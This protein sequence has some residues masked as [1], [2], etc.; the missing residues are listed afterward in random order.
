MGIEQMKELTALQMGRVSLQWF[1]H[2]ANN[3]ANP[4]VSQLIDEEGLEG[5]GRYWLLAEL[6]ALSESHALPKDPNERGYRK[7]VLG[8]KYKSADEFERFITLLTDLELVKVDEKGRRYIPCVTDA[9]KNIGKKRLSG[10]KGGRKAAD[11]RKRTRGND[12]E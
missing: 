6:L 3:G 7:Y 1:K 2:Q 11:N 4:F 8:L 12:G 10:S 5:Y 9:A